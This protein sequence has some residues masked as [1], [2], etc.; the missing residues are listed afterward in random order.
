MSGFNASA[1]ALT[2]KSFVGFLMAVATAAGFLSYEK[3]GRD[4]D[5]PF[6]IKTMIVQANW[7]GATA[8]EVARQV[9]DRIEKTLESLKY[10]DYTSSF[11]KA[12]QTVIMVNL[13]DTTPPGAVPDQWYQVRKKISDM[14]YQLPEGVQGPFFNDEFGD[15]Y[16]VIY[17]FT[18]DGFTYRELRDYIEFVRAELLRTP[19][20]GK[21]DLIGVQNEVIYVDFSTRQMSSMGLDPDVIAATLRVQNAVV[22]SGV[23]ETDNERIAIRVSG[24][25]DTVEN[26]SN[27]SVRANERF[28]RLGDIA[29]VSR[30]YEDPPT[31]MFRYQGEPAIGLGISMSAGGNILDL[32]RNVEE[33][34]KRIT[35]ALPV[36]IDVHLVA[37]QPHVVE[38]SVGAFTSALFEAIGIVL[39]V[40]FV[41]LGLRAG[42]VV[43]I[44]IPLVL[45]LT[46]LVMEFFKID[47]Q[48][49]S[50][51]ALVIALGL[52]VDDAMI[53]VEM[54]VLK[55]EE[56]WDR[57]R[58]ATFAY[59]STAFPM[60][61]GTVVTI[62]GFVPVGFAK[63]GAGE[64]CFTLFTV[65]AIALSASWIVA[66]IFTPFVGSAV[67]K[68]L[69]HA[70]GG[71]HHEG[72]FAKWFR[73][74][75]IRA[76]AHRKLV[77]GGTAAA[78]VLAVVAFGFVQ[79]QFFP[80]SD[81]PELLVDLRL[82]QNAS[83]EATLAQVKRV[84]KILESD[85]DI[86]SHTFYVGSGAVRFILALNV[87][88][89]NSNFAQAVVI[90]KG[91][92]E[93][94]AVQKRLARILDEQF[95][96]LAARVQP[97]QLGPPVSWPVQYRVGGP[98]IPT[99]KR[100]A[101]RIADVMRSHP[102]SQIVA[103][104]WIE[105]GKSVFI[106]VN[107]DKARMQG[108]SS[109][110][111]ASALNSLASGRTVTQ[112]RD[113]I[114]L[115]DLRGR[116]ADADR[117]DLKSVR[118]L[119]LHVGGN[120]V[121]L[122]QIATFRYELEDPIVWRRYRLPTITVSGELRKGVEAASVVEDQKAAI[123]RIAA[124]LP[125]GYKIELGGTV[126]SSSKGSSSIT[127]VVPVMLIGMVIVIMIQLQSVQKLIM[128]LLTA[129]LGI[130]GVSM[131]LLATF[132]PFGFV[133]M[134][135]VF[136]LIGMII[137]NGIV[138]IMQIRDHE[139]AGQPRY[140]A[141]IDATMHRMR[142]ILLTA[143]AA[144]LGLIPI[145]GEVFWGP[146][147]FAMMGG[148]LVATILTLI[149]LPA[150]YA[151][152]YR[153]QPGSVATPDGGAKIPAPDPH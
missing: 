29:R 121:P 48:R 118:E 69:K 111:I 8:E 114:Y 9:T 119:E 130:I 60:L 43:A 27:I 12:G 70:A 103:F 134:L 57:F 90:T 33:A 98:D 126:E 110:Q 147:A 21:V 49:I 20:V 149:F 11:A 15:V 148:L 152:W 86:V 78:F 3:L 35:Q 54:M 123:A 45:A 46:F 133:A 50:L 1:W 107:Q 38:E 145:A 61:T 97:L 22:A 16:G 105:T 41:S 85:P 109:S 13:K 52:L 127:A 25:F 67:L 80:A 146:M 55:L 6:T 106:D 125:A 102:A 87:E 37:N 124:E 75:L 94:D 4:E 92:K 136:A 73:P 44:C 143:A 51:G 139:K 14:R 47:L 30:G 64:Y 132:R 53:A 95:D 117:R 100:F 19:D 40:S 138:L 131:A 24:Q 62:I 153:V 56:G 7:P 88:L 32:G 10:I 151:A 101:N 140:E 17:G 34:M 150:L 91:F 26:I 135:G 71:G 23:V 108:V 66:V 113:D 93:R 5:P 129:P 115:I 72:R 99:V 142:P 58:A 144:I 2:H 28:V 82:P 81:R 63:S 120:T 39:L 141:I 79:Q 36:G 83:I 31:T 112:V 116:A 128:V 122:E 96:L 84:E 76:L 74:V 77:L 18:S 68:E 59:T 137:R 42:L 65:V 89:A 104:D